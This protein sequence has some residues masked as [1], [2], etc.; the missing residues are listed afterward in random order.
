MTYAPTI[1]ALIALALFVKKWLIPPSIMIIP[2]AMLIIRLYTVSRFG[3]ERTGGRSG[4]QNVREI[5][6]ALVGRILSLYN[7]RGL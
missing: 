4:V 7:W 6:F 5:H 1:I 3:S 2:T